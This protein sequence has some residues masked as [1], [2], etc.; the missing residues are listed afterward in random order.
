VVVVVGFVPFVGS[1]CALVD[2]DIHL[3]NNGISKGI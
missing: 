1:D 2:F 3:F